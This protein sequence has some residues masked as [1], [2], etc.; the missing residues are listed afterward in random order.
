MTDQ[1]PLFGGFPLPPAARR[2]DPETAWAAWKSIERD[3]VQ[4]MMA[5]V[6]EFIYATGEQGATNEEIASGLSHKLGAWS[7]TPRNRP[8]LRLG[9][10]CVD[11]RRLA[12]TGTRQIVWKARPFASAGARAAADA[13]IV[14]WLRAKGESG[15]NNGQV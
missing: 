10:L 13:E 5:A 8:L 4:R 3:K 6:Y 12:S 1:L 15:G 14:A 11:G 7:T 9:F 2:T